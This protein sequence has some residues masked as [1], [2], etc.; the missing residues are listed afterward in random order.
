MAQNQ[1]YNPEDAMSEIRDVGRDRA[2]QS[3][4][5][6]DISLN[7]EMGSPSFFPDTKVK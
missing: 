1:R 5:W 7:D 2:N 4:R 6:L 3:A